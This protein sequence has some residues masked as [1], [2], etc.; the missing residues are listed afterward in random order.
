KLSPQPT[1]QLSRDL[2]ELTVVAN[3][4]EVFLAREG[5]DHPVGINYLEKIQFPTLASIFGAMLAGV[6]Y[7]LMGAGTPRYIPGALDALAQGSPADL[8]S[9]VQGAEAGETRV[10]HFDPAAFFGGEAP[11]L[12]R[13]AFLAI[14][15]SATLALTL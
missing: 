2:T 3:F 13:P 4:A 15:S 8:R 1:L 12:Q 9:D 10:S 11:Q 6:G 14:V 7:A 5:H